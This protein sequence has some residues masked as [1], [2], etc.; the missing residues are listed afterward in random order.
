LQEY[1][2]TQDEFLDAGKEKWAGV[3]EA[4]SKVGST[5]TAVGAGVSMLGGIFSSLGLEEVG[6][7]FATVGNWITIVGTG[8]T[9]LGP[10][11]AGLGKIIT[12]WGVTCSL[13]WLWVTLIVA[14]IAVLVTGLI[15]MFNAMKKNS[16]EG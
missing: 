16:P 5:V 3:G 8:L 12:T 10:I 14:V 15:L 1:E 7:G 6:E 4:I 11:V 2:E 9:V 13:A